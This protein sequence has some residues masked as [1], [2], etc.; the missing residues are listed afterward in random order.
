MSETISY[1]AYLKESFA[2]KTD[3]NMEVR[4][5]LMEKGVSTK[6]DELQARIKKVFPVLETNNNFAISWEDGDG[7]QVVINTD[8]ELSIAM[9]EMPGPVYKINIAIKNPGGGGAVPDADTAPRVQ[10]GELHPYVTCD[11]CNGSVIG[12]RYKCLQCPDF[13]LCAKCEANGLHPGHNMMRLASAQGTWPHFF[14]KRLQRL[15]NRAAK[16]QQDRKED[17]VEETADTEKEKKEGKKMHKEDKKE[18]KEKKEDQ[19]E[20]SKQKPNVCGGFFGGQGP[21][22]FGPFMQAMGSFPHA[23]PPAMGSFS[24]CPPPGMGTFP[25]PPPPQAG[26][27]GAFNQAWAGSQF[28]HDLAH[29]E[30]MKAAQAAFQGNGCEKASFMSATSPNEYLKNLGSQVAAALDPFGINV[31]ISVETPAGVKTKVASSSNSSSSTTSSQAAAQQEDK[32]VN[33]VSQ[34]KES[35][36]AQPEEAS[37][38]ES[39]VSS[40]EGA[41]DDWTVVKEAVTE[42]KVEPTS[43]KQSKPLADKPAATSNATAPSTSVNGSPQSHSDPRIQ[44]AL[45]A[46]MNMGFS[47]EG[48]WLTSLLEAKQGDIGKVLDILQPVRKKT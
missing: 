48:G 13:D 2:T 31:D 20:P 37:A 45:Q 25:P 21:T 43:A 6:F 39:S 14:F 34:E 10:Q 18:K 47:N 26:M 24:P 8:E 16:K 38:R 3:N 12:H 23:P 32:E 46:M 4:R 40:T 30:A 5:F 1:K 27:Q 41:L 28:V 44:V 9:T 11:G 19:K 33:D 29:Q 35:D 42:E 7:D 15:Q 36:K 17:E 22:M